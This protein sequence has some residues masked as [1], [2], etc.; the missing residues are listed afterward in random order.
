M[1][2]SP[3][4]NLKFRSR[5]RCMEDTKIRREATREANSD[6]RRGERLARLVCSSVSGV[7][8]NTAIVPVVLNQFFA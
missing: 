3:R 6:L 8:R 5:V 7:L 4:T 1:T 2:S